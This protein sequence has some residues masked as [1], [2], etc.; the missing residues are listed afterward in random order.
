[1]LSNRPG[2]LWSE[3]SGLDELKFGGRRKVRQWASLYSRFIELMQQP[4]MTNVYFAFVRHS[5]IYF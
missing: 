2:V 3:I 5:K 4:Q 1:M